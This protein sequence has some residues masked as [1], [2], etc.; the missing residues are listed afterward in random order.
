MTEF[1]VGDLFVFHWSEVACHFARSFV[2]SVDHFFSATW[3][4]VSWMSELYL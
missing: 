3:P 2:G 4:V 1:C